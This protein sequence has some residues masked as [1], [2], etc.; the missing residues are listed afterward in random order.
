MICTEC[1]AELESKLGHAF[2]SLAALPHSD[3]KLYKSINGQDV[4]T[5]YGESGGVSNRSVAYLVR[6][7]ARLMLP[8]WVTDD[9]EPELAEAINSFDEK[10]RPWNR[11]LGVPE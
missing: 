9:C 5:V 8:F 6:T 11:D 3:L 4:F 7:K 10:C 1:G 2:D